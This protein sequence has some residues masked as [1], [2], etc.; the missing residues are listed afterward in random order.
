MAADV[1]G[2]R[3][4]DSLSFSV[5]AERDPLAALL[6]SFPGGAKVCLGTCVEWVGEWLGFLIYPFCT[7]TI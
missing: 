5:A 7:C 3:M 2:W 1:V 4:D 6:F